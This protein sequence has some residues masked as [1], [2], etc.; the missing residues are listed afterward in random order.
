MP[1]LINLISR[2]NL[3]SDKTKHKL[4]GN[5]KHHSFKTL[6]SIVMFLVSILYELQKCQNLF[7]VCTEH[8]EGLPQF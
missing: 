5:P 2:R 8:F 7:T 4:W 3:T 6:Y 1:V